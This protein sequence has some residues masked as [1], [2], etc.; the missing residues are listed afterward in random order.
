MLLP[1]LSKE[2]LACGI[3]AGQGACTLKHLGLAYQPDARPRFPQ[4]GIIDLPG[5][6]QACHEDPFLGRG[7]PQRHLAHQR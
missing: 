1:S 4:A 3:G 2:R 7:H 5:R 6:L